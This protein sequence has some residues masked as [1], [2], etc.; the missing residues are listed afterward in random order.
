MKIIISPQAFKGSL[1]SSQVAQIIAK[2]TKEIFPKAD[3]VIQPIADGGDGTLD[4]LLNTGPSNY[5]KTPFPWGELIDPSEAVIE[6]AQICGLTQYH[7]PQHHPFQ[8]SS[9]GLGKVILAALD[10]GLRHFFIGIGGTATNDAGV[11]M[12]Q[13]LGVRFLDSQGH[14]LAQGGAALIDLEEI[15]LTQLDPRIKESEF[16]GACDVANPLL[17]QQG[18][19][20]VY[21]PQKGASPEEAEQLEKALSNFAQ[22]VKR[23]TGREISDIRGGGAGGGI[24]AGL[25]FFLKAKLESGAYVIFDRLNLA[26]QLNGAD[27]IITGEG[28]LDEQTDYDKG[29]SILARLAKA[30]KI[31][32]L[33]LVGQLK[34]G[35]SNYDA[36][37]PLS[38]LPISSWENS[39]TSL[40]EATKQAL[41]CLKTGKLALEHIER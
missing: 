23:K 1:S 36:V 40:A 24:G 21:A 14:E 6:T 12:A 38:F 4:I 16:I 9:Y 30:K 28:Q 13:A 19:S 18:A 7:S 35:S 33:S 26:E 29:P 10:R 17:G 25:Y 15:D 41:R 22:V 31:P 39:E 34:N 37:I 5:H 11:G 27:L 2:T 3:L 8:N 20:L 32:I